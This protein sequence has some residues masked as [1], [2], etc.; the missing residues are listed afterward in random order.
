MESKDD[1]EEFLRS[2]K[3]GK[4]DPEQVEYWRKQIEREVG[5]QSEN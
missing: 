1:A 3:T 2:W 4:R 5:K